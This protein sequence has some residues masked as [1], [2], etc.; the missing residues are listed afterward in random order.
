MPARLPRVD[1]AKDPTQIADGQQQET[2]QT[3]SAKAFSYIPPERA[4]GFFM[5]PFNC[6]PGDCFSTNV[7]IS[8]TYYELFAGS[9]LSKHTQILRF[10]LRQLA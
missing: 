9:H 6:V 8:S 3:V 5:N 2:H 4:P 7:L 1:C 10:E